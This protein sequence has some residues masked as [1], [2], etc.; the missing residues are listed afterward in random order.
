MVVSSPASQVENEDTV[1]GEVGVVV[2]LRDLEGAERE[3]R[4]RRQFLAGL[5]VAGRF[6]QFESL[7]FGD[8]G[9]LYAWNCLNRRQ[10]ATYVNVIPKTQIVGVK[11]TQRTIRQNAIAESLRDGGFDMSTEVVR[12]HADCQ[13]QL[14]RHVLGGV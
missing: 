3:R 1:F 4:I 5:I 6:A 9:V 2:E 10:Q 8:H 11:E 14:E 13:R 7:Q 12:Q